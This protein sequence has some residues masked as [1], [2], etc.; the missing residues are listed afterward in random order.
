MRLRVWKPNLSRL[1]WQITATQPAGKK[2]KE[3]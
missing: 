3:T 2:E 1:L